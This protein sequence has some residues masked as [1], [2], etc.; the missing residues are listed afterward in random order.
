MSD[1]APFFSAG[2]AELGG[3]VEG[4]VRAHVDLWRQAPPVP[5]PPRRTYA[6]RDKKAAERELSGLVEALSSERLRTSFLDGALAAPATI[7]PGPLS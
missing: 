5:P 7:G 1:L 4:F 2:T 6:R 3:R